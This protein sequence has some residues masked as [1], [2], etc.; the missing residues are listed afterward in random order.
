LT[1]KQKQ[2]RL[3]NGTLLKQSF[4]VEGQAFLY[5]IVAIYETWVRVFEPDLK[6]QSNEGRSPTSLQ[7]Q[8]FRQ[9]QSKIK[10]MMIFAYDQ[11]GIIMTDRVPC[12]T[13]V[14]AVYYRD[15]TQKL[16]RKIHKN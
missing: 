12:G 15:W 13:S 1:A 6:S 11:R 7:P 9:A 14:T 4:N 10:E 16:R 5:Q 8:K 3:E 2:K